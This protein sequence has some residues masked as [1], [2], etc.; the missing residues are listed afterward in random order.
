MNCNKLNLVAWDKKR[1]KEFHLNDQET[2]I[3]KSINQSKALKGRVFSEETK[4]K[5][6]ES[7]KGR[8][9]WNKGI[10]SIR[11]KDPITGRFLKTNK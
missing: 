5:I 7:C 9:A 6:S 1:H 4:K 2:Q 10:K 11:K 8:V 3:K